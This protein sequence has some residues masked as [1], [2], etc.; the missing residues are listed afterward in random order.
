[1]ATVIGI[2]AGTRMALVMAMAKA[3]ARSGGVEADRDSDG[4]FVAPLLGFLRVL[5]DAIR[6]LAETRGIRL[7]SC[8]AKRSLVG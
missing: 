4:D 5:A 7:L 2:L 8:G 1:M 6:K 3:A